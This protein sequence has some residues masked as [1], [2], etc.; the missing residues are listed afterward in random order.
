MSIQK[1]RVTSNIV[2]LDVNLDEPETG[3]E[4]VLVRIG[5]W[6]PS[7]KCTR[8]WNMLSIYSAVLREALTPA[9]MWIDFKDTVT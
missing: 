3:G 6:Q 1:V 9:I 2:L 7:H 4:Q 5:A 8:W